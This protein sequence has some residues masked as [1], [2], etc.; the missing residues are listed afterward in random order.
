MNSK[1]EIALEHFITDYD[2][3]IADCSECEQS[4]AWNVDEYG[5]MAAFFESD[6]FAVAL[7]VMSADGVFERPEAEVLNRMF[8]TSYTSRD[9]R[10][11]Y[12][13]LK[14]VIDDY[15]DEEA[16]D[17]VTLLSQ[18]DPKLCEEYKRLILEACR[19]ISLSDG[20]AEGE[21]RLLIEKLRIA[22]E[23]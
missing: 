10:K 12:V 17:A 8:Q 16:G 1:A 23:G 22:L 20:V 13:S 4:G 2:A 5:Y 21:E 6:L 18:V 7:Q 9:L 3:F 11:L 14:P 15:C 19:I